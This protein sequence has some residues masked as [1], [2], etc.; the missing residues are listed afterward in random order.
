MT[1]ATSWGSA[2]KVAA[3]RMWLLTKF[4]FVLSGNRKLI[5]VEVN[6][7]LNALDG[8]KSGYVASLRIG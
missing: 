3:L 7:G 4:M 2:T 5:A 6:K 8:M 1:Q